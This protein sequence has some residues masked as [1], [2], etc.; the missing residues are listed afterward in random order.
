M[1]LL[2]PVCV[3]CARFFRP[4]RNGYRFTEGMPDGTWPSGLGPTPPGVEHDA[5]WQPY[6][7]W[8]GDLW[9]CQGCGA[10]IV[11]GVVAGPVAEHYQEGFAETRHQG[12]N[13]LQVN[14]C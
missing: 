4:E 2:K 7:L 10:E 9:R 11:V 12:F 3:P 6:K 14:D 13:Q 1:G 5:Y 8:V